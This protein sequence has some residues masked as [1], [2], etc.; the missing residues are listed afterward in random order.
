MPR[1]NVFDMPFSKVFQCLIQKAERKGRTKEEVIQVTCWLT[2][3]ENIDTQSDM[4]YGEFISGAPCWNPESD[5]IR[6]TIC[7][8]RVE[9]I[10]DP[11]TKK[12]RQ[13][14]K[15]IDDLAK[16][17]PTVIE[18]N[19]AMDTR[20]VIDIY[21]DAQEPEIQDLLRSV[22]RV[23]AE[24]IPDATEKI[25]YQMPTWYRGHNLIH[26]AAQKKHLGLYPGPEAVERFTDEIKERGLKFSKGAIQFPYDSVDL[27]L[28]GRIAKYCGEDGHQA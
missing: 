18:R 6:G 8:I 4:T 22:R 24:A 28:I 17:K 12:I 26:F 10:E 9:D 20:N 23:I 11:M 19:L 15:L 1:K 5:K 21:I 3:Y 14:D 7:G 25:S 2:G 16:G 13:L 27:D